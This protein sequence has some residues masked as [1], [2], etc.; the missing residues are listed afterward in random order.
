M[1]GNVIW[2]VLMSREVHAAVTLYEGA[3]G[4]RFERCAEA[5]FPCWVG[6]G[7]RNRVFAL[8]MDTTASDFP[9]ATEVWVPCMSVENLTERVKIAEKF[10]ATLLRPLFAIPDFGRIALLRQPG[11]AIVAWLLRPSR[12][13]AAN[14]AAA[15]TAVPG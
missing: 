4:W 15:V 9:A 2:T 3:L 10:G 12:P 5:P 7:A 14:R 8:F 13:S 6:R 1:P 11:G